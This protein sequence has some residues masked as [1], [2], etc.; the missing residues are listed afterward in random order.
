MT[1]LGEYG[2]DDIK[3]L[4]GEVKELQRWKKEHQEGHNHLAYSMQGY[5][6]AIQA[7][8]SAQSHSTDLSGIK[9]DVFALLDLTYTISSVGAKQLLEHWRSIPLGQPMQAWLAEWEAK[10]LGELYK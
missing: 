2:Y 6:E 4:I 5:A 9:A 1:D 7:L 8:Q 3:L 10:Y